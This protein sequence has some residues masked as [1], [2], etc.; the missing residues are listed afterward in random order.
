VAASPTPADACSPRR[1]LE[2]E[3]IPWLLKHRARLANRALIREQAFGDAINSPVLE[4]LGR[5]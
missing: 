3:V 2:D 5:Y 4:C 1:S